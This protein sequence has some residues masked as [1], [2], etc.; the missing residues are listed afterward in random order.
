MGTE[1][2]KSTPLIVTP[3]STF[4][5][6]G[7]QE[8]V[9]DTPRRAEEEEEGVEEAEEVEGL[10]EEEEGEESE[11]GEEDEIFIPPLQPLIA[12]PNLN[13]VGPIPVVSDD[14][15]SAMAEERTLLPNQF[16][17]GPDEDPGRAAHT[18]LMYCPAINQICSYCGKFGHFGAVCRTA[19][20]D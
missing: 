14:E 5:A 19:D 8:R 11:E 6:V 17:G 16:G 15:E 20:R 7:V 13:P 9:I 2:A 1:F 3:N 4:G 12:A 18:N 10:E